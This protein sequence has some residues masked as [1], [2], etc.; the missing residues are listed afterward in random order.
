MGLGLGTALLGGAVI[1]GGASLASGVMSSNAAKSAAKTQADAGRYAADLQ[2]QEQE[3]VRADLG[4]YNEVGQAATRQ[5]SS[6]FD[7]SNTDHTAELAALEHTPGYQFAL[8][9]GLKSTQNGAAARGLGI[10]GAAL[11][12]AAG[13]ATGLAQNTFQ[14]NLLNPLQSLA[15]L[16]E[17]AAAQTGTLGTTGAA[18]AGQALVG[19]ANASAAGTVG[20]AN[21]L[22]G[23]L[24]SVAN[25]A[26]SAPLNYL[27]YSKLLGTPGG[28][29]GASASNFYD[30]GAAG[31]TAGGAGTGTLESLGLYSPLSA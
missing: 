26:G 16:G 3:K 21:A 15:G 8:S 20:S 19:A 27:L 17:S 31:Y 25:A 7:G 12:G 2:Q 13:F 1:A 4:P 10:S 14:A 23:A 18:N 22:G 24:N 30:P 9:Q 6:Y 11:K 5:L 29:T 28:T